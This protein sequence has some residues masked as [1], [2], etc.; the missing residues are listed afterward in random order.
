MISSLL[1]QKEILLGAGRVHQRKLRIGTVICFANWEQTKNTSPNNLFFPLQSPHPKALWAIYVAHVLSSAPVRCLPLLS[2]ILVS[3]PLLTSPHLSLPLPASSLLTSLH[4]SSPFNST[5]LHGDSRPLGA[6]PP[7]AH[8]GPPALRGPAILIY[9]NILGS[10]WFCLIG[11][12][13]A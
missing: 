3:S 5:A 7:W 4:L 10:L 12:W 8:G 2:L 11:A 1:L 6:P 13:S 9:S